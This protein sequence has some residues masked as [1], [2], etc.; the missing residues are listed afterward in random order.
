MNKKP[1]IDDASIPMQVMQAQ[2]IKVL[3][4]HLAAAN[5]LNAKLTA[6]V[7]ALKN[8]LNP[9][10]PEALAASQSK[11]RRR[12]YTKELLMTIWMSHKAGRAI[13]EVAKI[14]K[15]DLAVMKVFVKG[16]YWTAAAQ[17]AYR[18]LGV[19]KSPKS[20]SQA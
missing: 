14:F 8:G 5:A 20:A 11:G 4:A 17:D 6:E 18:E 12:T 1:T 2:R 19:S 9:A 16:D 13:E 7:C 15:A 10:D 3:Q